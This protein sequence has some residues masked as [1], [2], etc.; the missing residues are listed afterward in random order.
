MESGKTYPFCCCVDI[1]L[2]IMVRFVYTDDISCSCGCQ[3][4]TLI[5]TL[6]L[7]S[8]HKF[9]DVLTILYQTEV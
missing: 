9:S 3:F 1:T 5:C 7:L 6:L 4:F 2:K 8:I